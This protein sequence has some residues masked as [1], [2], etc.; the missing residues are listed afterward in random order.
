MEELRSMTR[1]LAERYNAKVMTDTQCLSVPA[2]YS[3]IHHFL[4]GGHGFDMS[5]APTSG[6]SAY[7]KLKKII[8]ILQKM[9]EFCNL[10]V[11]CALK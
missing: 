3:M 11:A 10:V 1:S 8:I 4:R 5:L 6:K 2:C 9:Q 7:D